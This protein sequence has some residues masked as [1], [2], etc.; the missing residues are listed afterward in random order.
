MSFLAAGTAYTPQERGSSSPHISGQK[1]EVGGG[2][3]FD[4][5]SCNFKRSSSCKSSGAGLGHM[6][7]LLT[8]P[9][10]VTKIVCDRGFCIA[11]RDSS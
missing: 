4:K 3:R 8:T 2:E 10:G 1:A 5:G 9:K 6:W 7:L 11:L